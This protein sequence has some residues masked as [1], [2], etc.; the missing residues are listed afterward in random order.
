MIYKINMFT[1]RTWDRIYK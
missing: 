1:I